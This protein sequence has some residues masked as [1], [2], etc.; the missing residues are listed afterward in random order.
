[1]TAVLGSLDRMRGALGRLEAEL[2][3]GRQDAVL[4]V[5][6]DLADAVAHLGSAVA[7]LRSHGTAGPRRDREAEL[8]ALRQAIGEVRLAVRRCTALGVSSRI[9][10]ESTFQAWNDAYGADGKRAVALPPLPTIH[11]RS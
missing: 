3:A 4:G 7:T 2:V 1:M 10:M 8:N 6:T 11:S 5:E 9:W